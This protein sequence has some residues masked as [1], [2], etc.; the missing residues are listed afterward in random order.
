M[1]SL[2]GFTHVY[3]HFQKAIKNHFVILFICKISQNVSSEYKPNKS[4][5]KVSTYYWVI[6]LYSEDIFKDN[7][8]ANKSLDFF[9]NVFKTKT[10]KVCYTINTGTKSN[11]GC[12]NYL[13]LLNLLRKPHLSLCLADH[14][15]NKHF[16][17]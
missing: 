1:K 5:A 3:I 17:I 12:S 6:S 9:W 8:V 2:F 11:T 16:W 10:I 15:V 14:F 4:N 7:A 13:Y